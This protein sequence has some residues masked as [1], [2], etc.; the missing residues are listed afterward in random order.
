LRLAAGRLRAG[1]FAAVRGAGARRSLL[2][3]RRSASIKLTTLLGFGSS[4]VGS[5]LPALFEF[6]WIEFAFLGVEDM[7]R[8]LEHV[9]G[10][11]DIWN[12]IKIVIGVSHF[13]FVA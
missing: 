2:A 13:V 7:R 5:F 12:F 3:L 6:G 11:F 8:Q 10:D 9:G 1:P 4:M